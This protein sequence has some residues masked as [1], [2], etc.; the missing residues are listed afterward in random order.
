MMSSQAVKSETIILGGGC[1]WCTEAIFN[2]LEGVINVVPGYSGGL[3]ENP[4]Y[5][6]ICTQETGHAEVIKITF[7]PEKIN[8]RTLLEVFFATHDPTT[9]NRQG[10]DVGTQYRSII[11]YKNETQKA[12]AEAYINE[13]NANKTFKLPIVTQVIELDKFYEA[14][15]YH[16]D[17]YARNRN[18]PYCRFVIDPK[19][20]KVNTLFKPLLK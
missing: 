13:L 10:A 11:F 12:E 9:L 1:F 18:Q 6:E 5:N 3:L 4:S 2:K 16:F 17:Y 15:D 8:L 7:D 20:Q 19:I 14:E